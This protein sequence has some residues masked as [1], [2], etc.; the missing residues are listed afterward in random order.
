MNPLNDAQ[1][2]ISTVVEIPETLYYRIKRFIDRNP[3]W[4]QDSIYK[5]SL[6]QFL[7]QEQL[8]KESIAA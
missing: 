2:T 1:N 4:D 8:V 5:A 7:N 3:N 6:S